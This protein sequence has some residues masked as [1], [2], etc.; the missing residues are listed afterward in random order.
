VVS[1]LGI[2]VGGWNGSAQSHDGA[3]QWDGVINGMDELGD[4]RGGTHKGA[5]IVGK[6]NF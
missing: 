6:S 5:M 2:N 3:G 1:E 4:S